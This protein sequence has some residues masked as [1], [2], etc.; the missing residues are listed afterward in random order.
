MCDDELVLF[1]FLESDYNTSLRRRRLLAR[2][3]FNPFDW[4]DTEFM[5]RYRLSKNLVTKLCE[6]IRPMMN[7]PKRA[8]DLSVE[9]KVLTALSFFATGS[10][11]RPIGDIS[12]HSLAQQTVSKAIAQVTA[13]IN[14]ME[15]REKYIVFPRSHEDRNKIRARFYQKFGIPGVLGCID[16]TQI[17]IIRPTE[18]EERYFCRKHYH[19]LNVQLI[20]DADM[21]ITSVD[22]SF[23]GATHDS[24]I[25]N[26]HPIK[27]HLENLDETTWLLGDSGYPLRKFLMTPVVNALPETPEGHYTN[28]HV[29]ARNVI[30]RTIGLLKS[31]F[32]CLLAH[33]VLHYKPQV[34]ASIVNACVILHNICNK[35]NLPAPEISDADSSQEAQMQPAN[36][37][38]DTVS[39]SQNNQALQQ[40]VAIR[41]DLIRR[42]WDV[43][44]S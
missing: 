40:G 25:W 20:C 36:L 3:Q 35:A 6:E 27:N 16:C 33:R 42:L 17:A 43:R 8:T 10:Y 7:V 39:S 15:M 21:Q 14:S 37:A 24:F 44:R 1:E 2:N 34:A 9:T 32:R 11:Q 13:C 41:N 22:A 26:S 18:N 30:E 23:G 29:R 12:G 19:S 5:K 4:E 28:V 38:E 31:R